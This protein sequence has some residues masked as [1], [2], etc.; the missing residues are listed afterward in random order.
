MFSWIICNTSPFHLRL[1]TLILGI[2]YLGFDH[3]RPAIAYPPLLACPSRDVEPRKNIMSV[4]LAIKR[5]LAY[6][7]KM[8]TLQMQTPVD[9]RET[10]TPFKVKVHWLLHDAAFNN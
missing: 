4:E 8:A 9:S 6:Q 10:P 1:F 7:R 3:S 5:E 2:I